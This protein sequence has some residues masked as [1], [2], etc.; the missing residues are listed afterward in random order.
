MWGYIC[1]SLGPKHQH[2]LKKCAKY[3]NNQMYVRWFDQ[4]SDIKIIV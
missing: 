2:W 4:L 3:M 1:L